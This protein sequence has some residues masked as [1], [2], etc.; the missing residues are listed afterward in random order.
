MTR[1]EHRRIYFNDGSPEH[2]WSLNDPTAPELED[3][4]RS[5]RSIAYSPSVSEQQ[6]GA[7]VPTLVEVD[8][9]ALQRALGLVE[10][11][12][13]FA[14]YELGTEHVLR[15]LRELRAAL[16]AEGRAR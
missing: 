2:R 6:R 16:R 13:H 10:D 7:S 12:L 8:R 4:L 14:T 1:F 3:E 11:Y 9:R 5:L 15:Q